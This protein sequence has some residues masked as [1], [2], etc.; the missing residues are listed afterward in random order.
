MS[1]LYVVATPI[2]N[3]ADITLRAVRVLKDSDCIVCEDTRVTKKLLSHLQ[4]EKKT[5]SFHAQSDLSKLQSILALLKKG[6][7]VSLVTDAGTP[8][9][10][11]PG[12]LLVKQAR[13]LLGEKVSIVPIPGASA[14]TAALSVSGLPSSS[15]LFLGFLPHKKGRR[16]LLKEVLESR[17]T[18]VLYESPHRII[19]TLEA[20]KD[21]LD[22]ERR[23]VVCRELTKLF[24]E[25]IDGTPEEVFSYFQKNADKIKGEFVIVI[26]G[27]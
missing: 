15:F 3:L 14:L 16:S 9:I 24:E 22:K 25:I 26:S 7:N 5:I 19:K 8:T 11:D 10:S 18:A 21:L 2:G 23:V 12:M 4:I 13:K 6:Q 20:I 27:C 1:I 17:R